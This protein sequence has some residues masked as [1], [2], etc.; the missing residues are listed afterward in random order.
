MPYRLITPRLRPDKSRSVGTFN[1]ME[2]CTL[3]VCFG[4]GGVYGGTLHGQSC[5]PRKALVSGTV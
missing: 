3:A 1:M 2:R 5:D 4:R